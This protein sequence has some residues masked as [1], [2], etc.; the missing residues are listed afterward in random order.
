MASIRKRGTSYQARVIRQGF[1]PETKTFSSKLD[2]ERWARSVESAMDSRQY[3]CTREAE[4]TSFGELLRRYRETVTPM[5]RGAVEEAFRLKA[6]ERR[7]LAALSIVNVTP[8]VIADF[9]DERLRECCASTVIRDLAVLSS[10][11]NHARREWSLGISNPVALV[12]KTSSPPGRDRVLT[13][14][15]ECRLLHHAEPTGRRNPLLR[16][17]IVLAL[18]TAMRRGELL[19]LTWGDIHLDRSVVRLPLT[20]N[21]SARWVPLSSRAVAAVSGLDRDRHVRPF[22]ISIAAL[23][24]MFGRLCERAE[25]DGFRFHDLRHTATTRLAQRLPNVIEL[26][27]V[28]GHRLLQMLKRYYHPTPEGLAVKLG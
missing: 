21:G 26:A 16:P 20:K 13:P 1:P 24:K 7:R 22:P 23:D 9:R 27:A 28:T 12:R 3:V 14:D 6:L 8:Q 11:F 4:R 17:L 25:I 19:G 10:I 15:E 5:K 18:E 2:A